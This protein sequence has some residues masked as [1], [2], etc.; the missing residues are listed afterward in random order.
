MKSI[1]NKIEELENDGW[2]YETDYNTGNHLLKQ[3][4]TKEVEEF[5]K[6]YNKIKEIHDGKIT[7][8]RK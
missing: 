2:I 6:H 8:Y 1:K 5:G 7:D 4:L 3:C